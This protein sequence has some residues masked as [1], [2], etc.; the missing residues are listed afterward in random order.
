MPADDLSAH[1]GDGHGSSSIAYR[2]P[3]DAQIL[4]RALHDLTARFR[5]VLENASDVILQYDDAG[6]VLWASPSLRTTFGYDDLAVV[7][8]ALRFEHPD[9]A[10]AAE[11]LVETRMRDGLDV[12]DSS[13]RVVCAD[14]TLRTVTSRTRVVRY[15][16]GA[17]D[18]AVV[19]IRDVTEQV[20]AEAALSASEA[21]YRMLAD[22][23]TDL[24]LHT[25]A[26]TG[27]ID[28]VSPSVVTILGYASGELLGHRVVDLM[29]PDDLRPVR[30]V[31]RHSL[32]AGVRTGFVEARFRK[33]DGSWIWM[34]GSGRAVVAEDGTTLGGIDS[35]RDITGEHEMRAELERQARS[36]ALTGLPNRRD[37]IER[38]DAVL[39]HEPRAGTT[40]A[41]LFLDLD[42]LKELN[43]THG[44]RIGDAVIVE[45]GRRITATLRSDDVVGRIAGDEYVVLLPSLAAP[46]DAWHVADAIHARLARP[47][48]VGDARVRVSV[49][50]GLTV[51]R[52]G[53]RSE[54]V[55]HRADVALY[56]AKNAGRGRTEADVTEGSEPQPGT[57]DGELVVPS[58]RESFTGTAPTVPHD[59]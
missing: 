40:A 59:G 19:T 37:L 23:A 11:K 46:E 9:D 45:V 13:S 51:A 24:I 8:T 56:R 49:S 39:A 31:I 32:T 52:P 50:I 33:A 44:H 21:H 7:G 42:H 17:I 48:T 16:T 3:D 10:G 25:S 22:N 6:L 4:A 43:D 29:H 1:S 28:W 35:L 18:Y 12:I 47:V 26:A 53:D 34:S 15:P 54:D 36:D 20:E 14:G 5:L 2:P 27:L 30:G 58:P 38:L 57:G 55:L 41:V